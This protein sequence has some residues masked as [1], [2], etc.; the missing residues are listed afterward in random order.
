MTKK[1]RSKKASAT[2][3]VSLKATNSNPP[4]ALSVVDPDDLDAVLNSMDDDAVATAAEASAEEETPVVTIDKAAV[5]AEQTSKIE[6]GDED[7]SAEPVASS[8]AKSA[9]RKEEAHATPGAPRRSINTPVL[10]DLVGQEE[11]DRL[12]SG[13]E[14][15]PKKVQDKARNALAAVSNGSGLSTYTKIAVS[16]L[17]DNGGTITSAQLK[18]AMTKAGY[19]DRT[20]ASQS[21]QQM[22]VLDHLGVVIRDKKAHTLTLNSTSPIAVRLVA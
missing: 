20:V 8:K 10:V 6:S 18:E 9:K 19:K 4:P 14:K 16:A 11:A 7:V 3:E 17:Q 2:P 15:L 1:N 5:Y 12:V 22:A 21:Q 13:I